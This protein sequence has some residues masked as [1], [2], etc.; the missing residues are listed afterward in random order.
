MSPVRTLLFVPAARGHMI[1]RALEQRPDAI[2]LDLEDS[3][4]IPEKEAARAAARAAIPAFLARD[5]QVWVRINGTPTGLAKDDVRAVAVQGLSGIL[6]PKADSPEIVRYADALL[7]DAERLG[8]IEP[9][10]LRIVVTIESAR[11]LLHAEAIAAASP[12]VSGVAFGSED[13]A[14]D[15]QIVRTPAGEELAH[16]RGTIAVVARALGLLAID[17]VFPYLNDFEALERDAKA[18]RRAGFQ[19]KLL[20]HPQQI[21]TVSRIFGPSEAELEF[22]RRVLDAYEKAA[23]TGLGAIDVDGQM[24]DAPVAKRARDLLA[25]AGVFDGAG[26]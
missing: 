2:I 12:R 7:R 3:V 9:E 15:M 16:A 21:E 18:A 8:A 14:S 5:Q 4:P 17:T 10:T 22:A 25:S 24:V 11:G 19:A 20:I 6:L 13:F 26:A 1:E 23:L